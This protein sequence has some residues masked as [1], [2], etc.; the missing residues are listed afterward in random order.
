MDKRPFSDFGFIMDKSWYSDLGI[1][2]LLGIVLMTV[3]FFT[4]YYAGWITIT[5][6]FHSNKEEYSFAFGMISAGFMFI[7]VGFYE[8][9]QVRGYLLKNLS[10]G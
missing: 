5:D 1:G 6:Q 3:I 7:F 10:E 8:E 2:I 9:M 4:E